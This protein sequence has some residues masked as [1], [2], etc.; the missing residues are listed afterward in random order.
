MQYPNYT[1]YTIQ[2]SILTIKT[3]TQNEV[4][5]SY[6]RV[7]GLY[8]QPT[9]FAT[10]YNCDKKFLMSVSVTSNKSTTPLS[11][12]SLNYLKSCSSL[13]MSL[14]R[15]IFVS[16]KLHYRHRETGYQYLIMKYINFK[17]YLKVGSLHP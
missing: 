2:Y 10:H 12:I 8:L 5:L 9:V 6:H 7:R 14:W 17:L 16:T 13:F 4:A 1:L 3:T 11:K 15:P